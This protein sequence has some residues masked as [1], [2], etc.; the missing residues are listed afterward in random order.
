MTCKTNVKTAKIGNLDLHLMSKILKKLNYNSAM[1]AVQVME[2]MDN[3][4]RNEVRTMKLKTKKINIQDD[5]E[6][7]KNK[8]K[9][10]SVLKKG[11]YLQTYN[12]TV[13]SRTVSLRNAK[14]VLRI[15]DL[16]ID[17]DNKY[18]VVDKLS[19]SSSGSKN[20]QKPMKLHNF[21]KK[22]S[23]NAYKN[24]GAEVQAQLKNNIIEQIKVLGRFYGSLG[25]T[26]APRTILNKLIKEKKLIG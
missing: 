2:G 14:V 23:F 13:N 3:R 19:G 10:K 9:Y 20:I 4:L 25:S 22:Y 26:R 15:D 16:Y 12:T 1:S 11:E 6:Y 24:M 18:V 8:H 7:N 21:L 5:K 17:G